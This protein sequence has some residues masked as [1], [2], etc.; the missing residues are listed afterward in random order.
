M[1]VESQMPVVVGYLN[2]SID[3]FVQLASYVSVPCLNIFGQLIFTLIIISF[4]WMSRSKKNSKIKQSIFVF[5]FFFLFIPESY[6][7]EYFNNLNPTN[8]WIDYGG[9]IK[10]GSRLADPGDEVAVF[11]LNNEGQEVIVGATDIKSTYQE[12]YI[13]HVFEND[14]LEKVKNGAKK[15]R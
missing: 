8:S 11:V 12:Y 6:A 5:T 13:I 4:A 9:K 1:F 3:R 7:L 2:F 14:S 15:W 10:I